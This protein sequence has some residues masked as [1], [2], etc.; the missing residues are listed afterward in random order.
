[1]RSSADAICSRIARIGRSKPAIRI[2]VSMRASASRGVLAWTVVSEPSWPVFIA[3]SMSS[4]SP[5]GHSPTMMRSGR[6]RSALRTRSRIAT[7]ASALD[8]RP[9][10]L[11]ACSTWSCW[12][13]SSVG[14]L[15]RHDAL[16]LGDEVGQHVEHRGLAGAGTAG[17]DDVQSAA[18]TRLEEARPV[19]RADRAERDEVVDAERVLAELTD[20]EERAADG[21]GRHNGV[22]AGAVGQTRVDHR[23]RLVDAAADLSD[24]AAR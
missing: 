12:S 10:A 16:V 20:G 18:D 15:D 17:D 21:E 24:D 4:A 23:R 9:G 6:M 7:L 2:M 13:C 19:W 14:V 22:D 11:P 5:R 8:V 1:M 3:C